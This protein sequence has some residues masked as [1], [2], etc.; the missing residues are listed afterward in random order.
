MGLFGIGGRGETKT[1][2]DLRRPQS[3]VDIKVHTTLSSAKDFLESENFD[4][5]P[6]T[7]LLDW[8]SSVR[9]TVIQAIVLELGGQGTVVNAYDVTD[10]IKAG[11]E[12][13]DMIKPVNN[14]K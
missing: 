2:P 9:Q 13:N 12:Y 14:Q 11:P 8:T 10:M 3:I 7:A 5:T 1:L 6:S 4:M